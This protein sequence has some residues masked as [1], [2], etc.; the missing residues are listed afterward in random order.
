MAP[1]IAT[2][3]RCRR[4]RSTRRSSGFSPANATSSAPLVSLSGSLSSCSRAPCRRCGPLRQPHCPPV[5]ISSRRVLAEAAAVF[6]AA[7]ALLL[8][9]APTSPFTH[10]LGVCESG[11]VRDVLAGHIILPYFLPGPMVHVPPLYWWTAALCVRAFGWTE[12]AL[13]LP[14]MMAAALTCAA[15]FYWMAT[16]VGRQAAFFASAALLCCHF[17]LDAARQP[18]MDSMLALFVT[19]AAIFLERAHIADERPRC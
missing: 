8:A 17:V 19:V 16:R 3:S 9:L 13:R 18:R 11:A 10:E 1:I 2:I 15:L 5:R 12:L 7:F 14:S 4:P 6:A